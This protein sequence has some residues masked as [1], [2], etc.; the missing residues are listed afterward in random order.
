MSRSGHKDSGLKYE[1]SERLLSVCGMARVLAN[2]EPSLTWSE[3][4]A[5]YLASSGFAAS[6]FSFF[7]RSKLRTPETK[8]RCL[9]PPVLC[10]IASSSRRRFSGLHS[11]DRWAAARHH[12]W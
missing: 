9:K 2:V 3:T 8:A 6:E 5:M 1:R 4:R 7:A 12:D 10:Q 11:T